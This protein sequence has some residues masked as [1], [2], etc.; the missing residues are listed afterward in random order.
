MSTYLPK[1]Q[2]LTRLL[3][4]TKS[5]RKETEPPPFDTHPHL[6][7]LPRN[8]QRPPPFCKKRCITT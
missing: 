1:Q 7:P 4:I 2:K 6:H 5:S 8:S 3:K